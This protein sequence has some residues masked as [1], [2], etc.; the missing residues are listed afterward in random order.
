VD[1]RRQ[2]VT[3]PGVDPKTV[4]LVIGLLLVL[5]AAIYFAVS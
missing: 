2:L 4:A 5:C 3:N 1:E